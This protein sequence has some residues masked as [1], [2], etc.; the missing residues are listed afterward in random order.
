MKLVNVSNESRLV[1]LSKWGL[2]SKL[3][4]WM[5]SWQIGI[6]SCQEDIFGVWREVW[7]KLWEEM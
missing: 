1:G 2:I 6:M 5:M 7:P 4:S 3:V